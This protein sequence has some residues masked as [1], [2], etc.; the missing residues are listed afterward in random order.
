VT[1]RVRA[2]RCAPTWRACVTASRSSCS[3]TATWMS[4]VAA[5]GRSSIAA[6]SRRSGSRTPRPSSPP[7]TSSPRSTACS[8]VGPRST[9]GSRAS[10][11]RTRS[12][13]RSRGSAY[14]R[15]LLV[16]AAWHHT[17]EPRIGV[18]LRSRHEHQPDHVP[19]IAWRAQH[20][21]YRLHRRRR[22]R[23]KP[24]NIAVVAA[25]RELACFLWAAGTAS[26]TDNPLVSEA[27]G[28]KPPARATLR[29][30]TATAATLAPRPAHAG[31]ASSALR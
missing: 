16:E 6:G 7:S 3:A 30:A 25:A 2:S 17:R 11:R 19:P 4:V 8:P 10:R 18:T 31:D 14:A 29:C 20:R 24:G 23:G 15:R 28:P 22:E 13:R 27:P 9:N 26:P 12:G 5:A 21:R 1:W